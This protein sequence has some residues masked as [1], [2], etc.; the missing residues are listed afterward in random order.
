[1]GLPAVDGVLGYFVGV[2]T[3]GRGQARRLCLCWVLR[4]RYSALLVLRAECSSQGPSPGTSMGP[5]VCEQRPELGFPVQ[6][7]PDS[8]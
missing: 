1:M 3:K 6:T 7:A 8:V 4:V 5:P 2:A